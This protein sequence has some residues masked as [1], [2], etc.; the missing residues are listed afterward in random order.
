[1][2]VCRTDSDVDVD[3]EGRSSWSM[4][5]AVRCDGAPPDREEPLYVFLAYSFYLHPGYPFI[6]NKKKNRGV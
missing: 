1:M 4:N 3:L 5:V 6:S 2:W